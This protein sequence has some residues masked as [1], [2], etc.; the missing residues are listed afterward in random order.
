MTTTG[1]R[2]KVFY[3]ALFYSWFPKNEG[4]VCYYLPNLASFYQENHKFDWK[5]AF[6]ANNFDASLVFFS[7]SVHNLKK[8]GLRATS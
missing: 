4:E 1:C 6:D 2:T 5:T 8:N 3:V 7:L